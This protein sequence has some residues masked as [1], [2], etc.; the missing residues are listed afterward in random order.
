[1]WQTITKFV[2]ILLGDDMWAENGYLRQC[3]YRTCADKKAQERS[4][5][6]SGKARTH[7]P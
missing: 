4:G 7:A 2:A 1:M 5:E 6:D 3:L